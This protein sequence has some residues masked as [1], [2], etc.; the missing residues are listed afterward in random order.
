MLTLRYILRNLARHKL[1]NALTVIGVAVS[2]LAFGLLRT[3]VDAWYAGVA[4]SSSTRLVTRNAVSIIYTLPISYGERIRAVDGVTLVS[5]GNWFG[6]VY[7][8]EKNF[9]PNFA[10]QA[11]PYLTL[12][13]EIILDQAQK[14]VFLRDRKGCL[15]GRKLAAR[16][17]WKVG[18]PVTLRGTIY[19]GDWP[20][21]VRAVYRGRDTGVDE[22]QF[23]F[24]WEYLNESL[25]KTTPAL[26]DQA[27]FFLLGV[28]AP[29]LA[30]SASRAVDAIFANSLAETLTETEQAFQMGFVA[31]SEAIITAIQLISVLVI[32]IILAVAANTMAMTA[33]ER[34][35]EFAALKALGFGPGYLALLIFGESL[36]LSILGTG[37]GCGLT[38]P[39]AAAF[40]DALGQYFPIFQVSGLTVALQAGAALVVGLTAGAFP[41]WRAGRVGIAEALRRIG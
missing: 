3:T 41:A 30:A 37:L 9:F 40:G 12:Y 21:T 29:E 20:M 33:R 14:E 27:G 35:R 23:L 36:A 6:G 17:G 22:T 38:F 34:S 19:P 15:I 2:V 26:V 4:A 31:M 39:A 1:R 18:D 5:A 25:R 28:R 11:R 8:D 32:L 24:H 16:F 10:V 13:P 7:L